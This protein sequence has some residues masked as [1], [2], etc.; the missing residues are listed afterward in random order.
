MNLTNVYKVAY[1]NRKPLENNKDEAGDF[2]FSLFLCDIVESEIENKKEI[3]FIDFYCYLLDKTGLGLND[4]EYALHNQRYFSIKHLDCLLYQNFC[5]NPLF[6]KL[7]QVKNAMPELLDKSLDIEKIQNINVDNISNSDLLVALFIDLLKN[8][9]KNNLKNENYEYKKQGENL[10]KI[11]DRFNQL[12]NKQRDYPKLLE[13]YITKANLNTKKIRAITSKMLNECTSV[14]VEFIKNILNQSPKSKQVNSKPVAGD[15]IVKDDIDVSFENISKIKEKVIG[16]NQ[17]IQ[18]V[19]DKLLA[20]TVGFK[21]EK[22][23]VATFLLTGPTGVGKTETAKAIADCCYEGK[24]FTTDMATF[25]TDADISR[26]L[27]G[28]PN[29]VGYGD[30][31]AFCD[32][33]ENNPQCVLL[34]DEID[35]AS[36]GCLDLL[37]RMLDE[38]EFINAKGKTISL[39][40]AVIICTTN[41]TE[42]VDD[43]Q[44]MQLGEILTQKNGLRKEF[45]GRFQEV[46]EYKTLSKEACKQIAKQF[47]LNKKITGFE[48]SNKDKNIKLIYTEG[49]LNKVIEDANTNLFGARDLKKSIQKLFISPIAMYIV[50]N[51]PNN[52]ILEMNENGITELE[53]ITNQTQELNKQ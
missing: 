44:N 22:Q 39:K 1:G 35:K 31:V 34:F 53:Y 37:M 50:K 38:G 41:L 6:D 27:G 16:Q 21:D 40:D 52:V 30:K 7:N 18:T 42:Y 29:Y 49:F 45:V 20:S 3:S 24:L 8:V 13:Q 17:A 14:K 15:I 11:I 33:V 32:F 46:V 48:L 28:S 36:Q 12:P 9:V 43:K 10:L 19:C 5:E 25:K 51:K 4:L 2:V 26:L 47:F 23:P